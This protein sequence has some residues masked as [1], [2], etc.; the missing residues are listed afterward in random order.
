MTFREKRIAFQTIVIREVLRFSRIWIQTILPPVVTTA[1][2]FIIFGNLI[3]SQIGDMAGYPYVDYI[4]PGLIMMSVIT[5]AYANVVS[6]FYGAKFQHHIEEMLV[7]PIPNAL[8]LSGYV[9]GGV[10][11]GL[12]VGL[13]VTLTASVFAD[14]RVHDLGIALAMVLLTAILFSIGGFING[15][16]ARSFDDISLIPTFVLTPLTYL[17][18]IFYSIDMLPEFWQKA[19]LANPILYMINSFRYGML[20]VSDIGLGVSF[21]ITLAFIA[22]LFAFAVNLLNR[23]VGIRS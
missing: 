19:S 2:Y 5:N 21:A 1:L 7:S 14:L 16:Y 9:A 15:I 8:I 11:R 12:T 10:A 23:G 20:G 4:V 3:G 18:G 22:V 13:A 6:S 17:G